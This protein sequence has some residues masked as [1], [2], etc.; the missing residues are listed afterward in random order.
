MLAPQAG[1]IPCEERD[2][3]PMTALTLPDLACQV[4]SVKYAHHFGLDS[5]VTV[6]E[7]LVL[8]ASLMHFIN[9][10]PSLSFALLGASAL[11]DGFCGTICFAERATETVLGDRSCPTNRSAGRATETVFG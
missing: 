2:S 3:K 9:E 8:Q 5:F 11:T 6:G 4:G 1:T 7:H 10:V